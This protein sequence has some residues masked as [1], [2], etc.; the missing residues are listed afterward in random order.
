MMM[1]NNEKWPSFDDYSPTSFGYLGSH[2]NILRKG[3]NM[4]ELIPAVVYARFSSSG[5]RE[6]SITGQLRDCKRYAENHGFEIINEYIDEA[7]TGTSD[8]RPSFQKMI[9]DSESKRFNAIIVWKLDR[10][11]RNRYDSAI[12]RARL[13]KNGV[14]IY[15]AMEN[16]SDSAEGIIMEGLMESMAEYYSANLSENV[17]RGNRESALQLKT[18]GR[19]IFGYGRS[20]DDHY[21]INET[22]APVVRRIFN[23]Y[24]S[25]KSIQDIIKGLNNDGIM[26]SR[27]NPWNKSSLKNIIGNDKYIGTYRFMD[28]VVPDGMP[29]IIS[30]EMFSVAQEIKD[31]HKKSPARSREAR[32]L[33]TGK[34]FCGHCGS[35]MTGEYGVS[36]TGKKYHYYRCI[37]ANKHKCDKKRAKKDWIENIVVAELINQLNDLTYIDQLAD[38]F[39][40]YQKKQQSDDS[41]LKVLQDRLHGVNKSLSNMV[42]AIEMG[43]ITPTTQARME[44]LEEQ[45]QQLHTSIEQLK[46]SKPPMIE[47]DEFLF[48]IDTLKQDT[49]NYDFKEKLIDIFLNAVYLYD[50]GYIDIGTNLIKGTKRIDSSTLEQLC[51]PTYSKSNSEILIINNVCLRRVYIQ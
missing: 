43:I 29:A 13:K 34:L 4:K 40:E 1:K 35:P 42:K 32:Y 10:F 36:K 31:R 3:N 8:N 24:T 20:E 27:N 6:E 16:I 26:N 5:Q 37:K 50:D 22:E 15:S 25:G 23:E 19:K 21:I 14:K 30:K 47:R 44:E 18:L 28:Y 51:L 38:R 7:K 11:A 12:Y 33:L 9:K 48:W 45:K 17:K 41:E 49:G 2:Y 39:M 46:F